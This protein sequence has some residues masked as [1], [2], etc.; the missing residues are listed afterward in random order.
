M[1]VFCSV[2]ALSVLFWFYCSL[3]CFRLQR[4]SVLVSLTVILK[5]LALLVIAVSSPGGVAY[6]FYAAFWHCQ[7]ICGFTVA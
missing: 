2:M 7:F 1:C 3:I 6:V 5:T 4:M